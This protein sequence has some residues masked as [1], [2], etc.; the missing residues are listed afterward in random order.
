MDDLEHQ[1]LGRF[2]REGAGWL[3]RSDPSA[4]FYD[5]FIMAD[6]DAP[7]STQALNTLTQA[8]ADMP[9]LKA[10]AAEA[11]CAART[12]RLNW[13]AGPNVD[14]WS[15]IEARLD[16]AGEL[17]LTLADDNDEYSRWLVHMAA[18]LDVRRIPALALEGDPDQAGVLV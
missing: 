11:I 5:L 2:R 6:E 10:R 9:A 8:V 3:G 14:A 12:A 1:A 16:R 15:I 7:P 4:S 13:R 18:T 17:W